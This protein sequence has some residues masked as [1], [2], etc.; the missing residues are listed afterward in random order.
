MNFYK[1]RHKPTGLFYQPTR[2]G[3]NLSKRGKVYHLK[4]TL[5]H[6]KHCI[7]GT[8]RIAS[9]FSDCERI[10]FIYAD[11]EIVHF[12]VVEVKE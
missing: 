4:P 5:E 11:W 2:N 9:R 3:T 8:K 1:I 10:P 12:A 7:R 6:I